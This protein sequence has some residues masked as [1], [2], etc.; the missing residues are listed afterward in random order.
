[1]TDAQRIPRVTARERIASG[2]RA[3]ALHIAVVAGCVPPQQ[4]AAERVELLLVPGAIAVPAVMSPVPAAAGFSR[5]VPL[6]PTSTTA[7]R[8]IRIDVNRAGRW[9]A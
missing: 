5:N 2:I 7:T 1:M 8:L 3:A 9:I 6:T 4:P